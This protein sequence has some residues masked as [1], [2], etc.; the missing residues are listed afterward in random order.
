MIASH[1]TASDAVQ[2]WQGDLE[3]SK[4]HWLYSSQG[5]LCHNCEKRIAFASKQTH[6]A[7]RHH[8]RAA[9]LRPPNNVYVCG[10]TQR[11]GIQIPAVCAACSRMKTGV[12]VVG[13]N[14]DRR[15]R[16]PPP[17]QRAQQRQRDGGLTAGRRRRCDD[18]ARQ[19]FGIRCEAL[20][21]FMPRRLSRG[22]RLSGERRCVVTIHA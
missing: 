11:P 16:L 22:D 20:G 4:N 9:C 10:R 3:T 15:D 18:Q 6:H 2:A 1:R 21:R 13:A 14:L 5:L 19:F 8:Q 7:F 17:G 12:D